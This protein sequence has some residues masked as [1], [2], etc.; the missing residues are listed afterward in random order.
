MAPFAPNELKGAVKKTLPD[1]SPGP[2]GITNRRSQ[3]GDDDF[4]ALVL[5]F[6]DGIRESQTQ[7]RARQLSLLQPI[8]KGHN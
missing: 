4:Q 6:F 7:P 8:H 5:I 2:S 3:A 1:K